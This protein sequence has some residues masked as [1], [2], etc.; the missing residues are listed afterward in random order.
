MIEGSEGKE[1][2]E[3]Y[4]GTFGGDVSVWDLESDETFLSNKRIAIVLTQAKG[5]SRAGR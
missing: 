5:S 1:D 3:G 2:C 4:S